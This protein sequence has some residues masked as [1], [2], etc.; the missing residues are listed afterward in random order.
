LAFLFS[1]FSLFFNRYFILFFLILSFCVC[2]VSSVLGS[3][4][5]FRHNPP[6]GTGRSHGGRGG[7]GGGEVVATGDGVFLF[8]IISFEPFVVSFLVLSFF[9]PLLLYPFSCAPSSPSLVPL[10]VFLLPLPLHGCPTS[11]LRHNGGVAW[12]WTG[13]EPVPWSVSRPVP[14][15]A[16]FFFLPSFF[17]VSP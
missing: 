3:C 10:L 17:V 12:R 5:V 8:T 13:S 6:H 2:F 4:L 15:P 7:G 1:F 9:L 14:L 16:F 11:S